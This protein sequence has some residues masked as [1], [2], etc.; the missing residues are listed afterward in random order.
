[1][2]EE[3]LNTVPGIAVLADDLSGAAEVAGTFL[4]RAT[5]V[6]LRLDTFRRWPGVV[7]ADLNTRTMTQLDAVRTMRAA[8][9]EIPAGTRVVKKI[10]SL[11]RGHVGAEI[12]V[13]A[14]R[15]PVIV[16]AALPSLGRTVRN[17]VL[18]LGDTP[19]HET[20]AWAAEPELPPHAVA[21]L[22]VGRPLTLIGTG[23]GVADAMVR[24][25]DAGR[26]A[27]CD[28]QTDADLDAIVSAGLRI[29]GVQFVGTSAL[30]S[31]VA[32]TLPPGQTT[33][34]E[35]Q[36]ATT[37]LTV[38]GTAAPVAASQVESL[39]ADGARA[40]TVDARA[41]LHDKADPEPIQ[42]AL[43]RGSTV[44]TIGGVLDPA[45][46]QPVSAALGH[47]IATAQAQHRP[48]LVLTGGETARAVV[49]AI[50]ITSLRP[51]HEI[52]HGAV[53][54]VASDGRRVVTRPGSFGDANSLVTIARYLTQR[55]E[56]NA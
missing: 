8:L 21:D 49:D 15:G 37:V 26:I 20:R 50:G 1:M 7:V 46:A 43:S 23:D 19:L 6:S 11:L 33:A 2:T 31:A 27:V 36:P 38:I 17:G 18:H 5:S 29:P 9:A 22:F 30:A 55:S 34:Y 52:H 56:D 10:D 39:V 32:R 54:S 51:V 40:V 35:R 12:A 28:G 53:V 4:G 13:L 24:A 48:D 44:V 42:R 41:L 25:A 14:K 16:A 45:E 47:F 3:S